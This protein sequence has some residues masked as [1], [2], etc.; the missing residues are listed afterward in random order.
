[1]VPKFIFADPLYVNILRLNRQP[2]RQEYSI[3]FDKLL[4]IKSRAAPQ[5]LQNRSSENKMLCF[6]EPK[7]FLKSK[8]NL[9][10]NCWVYKL[11]KKFSLIFTSAIFVDLFLQN[12]RCSLTNTSFLLKK[13]NYL[14]KFLSCSSTLDK[15]GRTGT[16]L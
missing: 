3:Q 16:G 5:I 10:V 1:M 9:A 8:N 12:P 2:F 11:L 6:M 15:S 4:R 7:A 14:A 13:E